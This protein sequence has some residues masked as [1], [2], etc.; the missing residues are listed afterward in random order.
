MDSILIS[1]LFTTIDDQPDCVLLPVQFRTPSVLRPFVALCIPTQRRR[2]IGVEALKLSLHTW[3]S[4]Q[5]FFVDAAQQIICGME[6]ATPSVLRCG[7]R[8]I[9]VARLRNLITDAKT[10]AY[11]RTSHPAARW[12]V[13]HK[14]L[15]ARGKLKFID[16]ANRTRRSIVAS[17]RL[18]PPL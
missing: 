2:L 15:H 13:P 10:L 17:C 9:L 5:C 7:Q 16:C 12:L 8:A 4:T 6:T 14:R 18:Q 3:R 11:K 1:D